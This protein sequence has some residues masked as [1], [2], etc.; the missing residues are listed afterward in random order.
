MAVESSP[1]EARHHPCIQGDAKEA[2]GYG[3]ASYEPHPA[4]ATMMAVWI[5]VWIG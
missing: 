4:T 5:R 1:P 2:A 3:A